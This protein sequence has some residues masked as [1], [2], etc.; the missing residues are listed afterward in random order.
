MA[1]TNRESA[2]WFRRMGEF[3]GGYPDYYLVFDLETNGVDA[4]DCAVLPTQVGWMLVTRAGPRPPRSAYIN[5]GLDPRI[6]ADRFYF[7]VDQTRAAMLA[8][9]NSAVAAE[10][11]RREGVTPRAALGPLY[12][13]LAINGPAAAPRLVGFNCFAFDRPILNRAFRYA[14]GPSAGLVSGDTLL[15]AGMIAKARYLRGRSEKGEP[16]PLGTSVADWYRAMGGVY[17]PGRWGLSFCMNAFEVPWP[18]DA[19]SLHDAAA[20]CQ[21][22]AALLEAFKRIARDAG[23]SEGSVDR[24]A[25]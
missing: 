24:G 16:P 12:D 13:I 10:T 5:W 14:F 3:L 19:G 20:D 2:S 8:K 4:H 22:T 15:D 1:A 7:S 11:L 18:V 17:Y 6:D 21:C 9:G 23:E 25:A